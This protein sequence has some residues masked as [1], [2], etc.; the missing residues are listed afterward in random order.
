MLNTRLSHL[1]LL[2]QTHREELKEQPQAVQ[3]G[4]RFEAVAALSFTSK[5]TYMSPFFICL[6]VVTDCKHE[7]N[8]RD[9]AA[10]FFFNNL[11][12]QWYG[13]G[14]TRALYCG[15]DG[16][17]ENGGGWGE[18]FSL[19]QKQKEHK[20]AQNRTNVFSEEEKEN[21]GSFHFVY[22]TV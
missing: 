19:N 12:Q 7:Q 20:T 21:G 1:Q 16:I 3:R 17:T 11:L 10:V 5:V 6:C 13:K 2:V 4:R 9:T 14:C 18:D 8:Y 22:T 15:N